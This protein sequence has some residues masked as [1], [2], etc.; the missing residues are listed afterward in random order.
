MLLTRK[1][2]I[3]ELSNLSSASWKSWCLWKNLIVTQNIEEY[4]IQFHD[5]ENRNRLEEDAEFYILIIPRL[6]VKYK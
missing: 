1:K 5:I 2:K 4:K 6:F 3:Y